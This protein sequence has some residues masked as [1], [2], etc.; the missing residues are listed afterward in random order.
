MASDNWVYE[1]C[2]ITRVFSLAQET[3][4]PAISPRTGAAFENTELVGV[5]IIKGV[6][7]SLDE[8]LCDVRRA[9]HLNLKRLQPVFSSRSEYWKVENVR[10][11]D[12]EC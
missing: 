4:E 10:Q 6:Q 8:L 7:Q 3:S 11:S 2:G 5:P 12:A 9:V 1:R